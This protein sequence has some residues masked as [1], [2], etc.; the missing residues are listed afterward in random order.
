[1]SILFQD[2][3]EKRS[4]ADFKRHPILII[5]DDEDYLEILKRGL[6]N[7]FALITLS[8]FRNLKKEIYGLRPSLIMLDHHLG[9]TQP[10]DVLEFIQSLDFLQKTPLY[11]IS[12]NNCGKKLVA[13]YKLE[14]FMVK[15]ASLQ[16]VRNM[17]NSAISRIEH[18]SKK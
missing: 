12:A 2:T 14:G 1:M 16:G 17:L 8:G 4:M 15:P 11:L 6:S 5:D 3:V 10:E 13:E 7:E 18:Q 9:D